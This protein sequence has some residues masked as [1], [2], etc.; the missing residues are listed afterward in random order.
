MWHCGNLV[1][2]AAWERPA[3]V[4]SMVIGSLYKRRE[5]CKYAC[6]VKLSEVKYRKESSMYVSST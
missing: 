5:C 2:A 6:K 1:T 4:L 3:V